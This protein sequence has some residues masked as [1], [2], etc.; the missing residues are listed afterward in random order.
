VGNRDPERKKEVGVR[1]KKPSIGKHDI[2]VL[3]ANAPLKAV[4]GS[5]AVGELVTNTPY[6]VWNQIGTD[7]GLRRRMFH[8]RFAKANRV[9][10]SKCASHAA[11][12]PSLPVGRSVALP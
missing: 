7:P 11:S 8:K 9:T 6:G 3:Y 1:S 2:V 4:V 5:F 10:A 12:I